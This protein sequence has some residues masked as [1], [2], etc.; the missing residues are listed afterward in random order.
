MKNKY[1]SNKHYAISQENKQKV[2]DFT[3]DYIQA[4]GYAPLLREIGQGVGLSIG[5]V[6][7]Y[8]QRLFTEGLLVTDYNSGAVRNIRL[9]EKSA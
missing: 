6:S 4:H 8:L 9:P 7:K 3:A 5:A 2:Y 1:C